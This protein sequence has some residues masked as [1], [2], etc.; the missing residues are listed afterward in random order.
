M[1]RAGMAMMVALMAPWELATA[2]ITVD[3]RT[4]EPEWQQA[5][6]FTDF[7]ATTPFTGEPAPESVRTE[8]WLLST[9]EGIAVAIRSRHP[10]DVARIDSRVQR[11]F[12]EQVDRVNFM[13]DFD[14]DGKAAY[15][16]TVSASNDISDETIARE[17]QFSKDWDAD[18]K[19][20][21]IA[22]EEG[23]AWEMLIPWSIT[24]MKPATNGKRTI[25]V[26]FDRVVGSTG[27]RFAT[28]K[29]TYT[30]PRFVS[31]FTRIEIDA[32]EQS[33]LAVTPYGVALADLKNSDQDF[34]AGADVFWKPNGNHQFALTLNPD[35]GQVESD[36]LVVNFDA[37]ETFFSDK[38]PFFTDNQA[39]FASAMSGGNLFYTRRVGG[40]ADDGSGAA[41][42]RAAVKANGHAAG[43]DYAFFGATEDGDAGRDFA[44]A[45]LAH[46]TDGQVVDL[47]RIEVDRPFLDRRASVTAVHGVFRPNDA[48]TLDTAVHQSAIDVAGTTTTGYG[49]GIIADWDIPG[50]FRQ[51]YFLTWVDRDENVNDLG[52]QDR[53]NFRL[54]EWETGYRQDNLP[55]DSPFASHSWEF[56]LVGMSNQDGESL[57]QTATVQRYSELRTGGNVFYWL[58]WR[59]DAFDDLASRGNGSFRTAGGFEFFTEGLLSRRNDGRISWYYTGQVSEGIIDDSIGWNLGLEPRFHVNGH[60]DVSL[61]LYANRRDAWL[62]WQGGNRFGTFA[63]DR[64]DL[65]SNIN[66]F[67]DE[68]QELRVKLQALGIDAEARRALVVT[69][70]RQLQPGAHPIE[71]FRLRRLGFQ[72]RY[73]YKLDTLSDVFVVYSRGGSATE[74]VSRDDP[75]GALGSAFDLRDDDQFLVKLAY[76][77][78]I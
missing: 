78:E 31:D 41:D 14:A 17:N 27:Q 74:E 5:R 39:A 45:R 21:A 3:G 42:I 52:F 34:K 2:A 47:T 69:P 38:R 44:L 13:V 7:V 55:E 33:L 58:R 11:D 23:Y 75:L 15:D 64:L 48:W 72:V 46:R 30:Q 1:A 29:A 25:A 19:H 57:R 61:G 12:D 73:R 62:L 4:D 70:D 53:N 16:F 77:F 20:A 68:R 66:W 22:T 32:Y 63:A 50:P 6:H 65:V 54:A 8:A 24:S 59:D 71:D 37:V 10:K 28:P 51:Q 26:Y 56:E 43:L 49:G 35:F 60:L 36:D 67:F 18:W 76:R 40:P 9:P